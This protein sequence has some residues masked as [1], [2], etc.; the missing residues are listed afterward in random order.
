M[1]FS[2][3]LWPIA[4]VL[5]SSCGDAVR[6][7]T[8]FNQNVRPDSVERTTLYVPPRPTVIKPADI[9]AISVISQ[10][11]GEKENLLDVVNRG[12]MS[13]GVTAA[14]TGGGAVGVNG[15]LVDADGF[16]S[17]PVFGK[18]KMGGLTIPEAKTLVTQKI[19]TLSTEPVAVE[20]RITNFKVTVIGE[21]PRPGPVIAPNHE[22]NLMDAISAAGDLPLTARRDN[23][24]VI[25]EENG[26]RVEARVN[27][28]SSEAFTSPYYKLQQND[29]IIVEPSRLRRQEQNEFLRFY[30]PIILGVIQTGVTFF[31]VRE[32]TR[33]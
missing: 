8:Y 12:G 2:T 3:R 16:I 28:N 29:Q 11:P 25:R 5:F 23:I 26:Q 7:T 20:V 17:Y 32:A 13:Y 15:Y 24:K 10:V 1:H 14:A 27:L 18:L 21:V 6:K 4:I 9:L 33:N 19:G 31:Y 22:I 30:L